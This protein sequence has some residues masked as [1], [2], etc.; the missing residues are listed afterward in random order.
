MSNANKGAERR[1][2]H[3]V[4]VLE[5]VTD[6]SGVTEYGDCD[7]RLNIGAIE[8]ER[9]NL[10]PN[11]RYAVLMVPI[12]D[13][14]RL[15]KVGDMVAST[16]KFKH[17]QPATNE[18]SW[19]VSIIEG[20][21]LGVVNTGIYTTPIKTERDEKREAIEAEIAAAQERLDAAQKQLETL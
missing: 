15:A 21:P 11:T 6:K 1:M 5:M 3:D 9:D 18:A 19:D 13:G 7:A 20:D 17:T 10:A 8:W 4:R 12:P 14:E 2:K 16:L